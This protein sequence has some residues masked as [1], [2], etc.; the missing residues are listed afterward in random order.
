MGNF[1]RHVDAPCARKN[2][3]NVGN[4]DALQWFE[5]FLVQGKL[6]IWGESTKISKLNLDVPLK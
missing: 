6:Y 5:L 2:A 4:D 1:H 3:N